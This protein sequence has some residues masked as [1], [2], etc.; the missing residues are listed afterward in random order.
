MGNRSRLVVGAA[1]ATGAGAGIQAVRRARRRA[2]LRAIAE[3]IQD[4]ILPT[5]LPPGVEEGP[6]ADESH[7]P[8]HQHLGPPDQT[9]ADA[10]PDRPIQRPW[11]KH[12][13]GLRHPGRG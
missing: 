3:G 1:A 12:H 13:H 8:G 11:T 2:R 5:H 6:T 9:D 7:A 4:S 10:M